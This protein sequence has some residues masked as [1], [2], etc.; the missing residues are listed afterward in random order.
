ML[1]RTVDQLSMMV[2]N[3]LDRPL[4]LKVSDCNPSETAI[5]LESLDEDALGDESESWY[6]LENAIV[7]GLV[8]GNG[9][10]RLVL[11]LPL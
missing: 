10:L 4:F 11:N 9:V 3:A 8:E 2:N 6:F 5:N 1:R 7:G